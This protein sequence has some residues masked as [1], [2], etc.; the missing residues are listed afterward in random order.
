[1]RRRVFKQLKRRGN[2]LIVWLLP[3]TAFPGIVSALLRAALLVK[4]KAQEV[5]I[6]GDLLAPSKGED[7]E[8]GGEL[9]FAG[10]NEAPLAALHVHCVKLRIL[11]VIFH[12]AILGYSLFQGLYNQLVSL[13]YGLF[14][15]R[16]LGHLRLQVL[17]VLAFLLLL[18]DVLRGLCD[19]PVEHL[20]IDLA[21]FRALLHVRDH[22]VQVL[23]EVVLDHF[24]LV[25]VFNEFAK[26]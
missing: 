16:L 9:G 13:A 15:P 2:E 11:Y 20:L 19:Q 17:L 8:V 23:P 26:L 18:D 4:L 21:E 14:L 3:D 7:V 25:R 12:H 1:M 6:L 10:V 22:F 24:V 5:R